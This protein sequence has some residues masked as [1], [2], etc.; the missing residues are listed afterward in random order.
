MASGSIKV[1]ITSRAGEVSLIV[2]AK[3]IIQARKMRIVTQPSQEQGYH[4]HPNNFRL[5][6]NFFFIG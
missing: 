1:N 3:K 6:H 4:P 2:P 5:N